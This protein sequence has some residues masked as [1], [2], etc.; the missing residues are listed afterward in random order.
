LPTAYALSEAL[1]IVSL[2]EGTVIPEIFAFA[3]ELVLLVKAYV[4][5]SIL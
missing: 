5:I 3:L 1:A 4:T 2:I